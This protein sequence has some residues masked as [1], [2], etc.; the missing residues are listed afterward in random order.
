MLYHSPPSLRWQICHD[1][2]Y[3]TVQLGT[4]LFQSVSSIVVKSLMMSSW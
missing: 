4:L 3:G 1:Q 2:I